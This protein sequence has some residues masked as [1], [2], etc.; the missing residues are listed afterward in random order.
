METKVYM[1]CTESKGITYMVIGKTEDE[2]VTPGCDA[3]LGYTIYDEHRKLVDGGTFEYDASEAEKKYDGW[4][5]A[6]AADHAYGE[7][8]RVMRSELGPEDFEE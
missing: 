3:C 4:L 8:N 5:V 7:T 2:P 1:V 6:K